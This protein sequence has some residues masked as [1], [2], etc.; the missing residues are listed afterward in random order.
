MRNLFIIMLSVLINSNLICQQ[1]PLSKEYIV[2]SYS[3][4]PAYAGINGG[5][6]LF[7]Q[8]RKN[9][10]GQVN[11]P[12]I[13]KLSINGSVFNHVG[14][15]LNFS[16]YRRGIFNTISFETSYS[17]QILIKEEHLISFGLSAILLKNNINLA[18]VD[19]LGY[20]PYFN[21]ESNFS[22]V[23]VNFGTGIV[24]NYNGIRLGIT[25]PLLLKNKIKN[26]GYVV[27][28]TDS[29]IGLH[30]GYVFR[31]NLLTFYPMILLHHFSGYN[32]W[33][34]SFLCQLRNTVWGGLSFGKNKSVGICLGGA[35]FENVI[36]NYSYEL[37]G[38]PAKA[39]Y[40]GSHELNV[41]VLINKKRRTNNNL[42]MF[43]AY[44][45]QPYHILLEK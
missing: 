41:G 34:G 9:L 40:S 42:S 17:Y 37:S 24:Y 13:N 22:T 6:E 14:L 15:G 3:I 19:E 33:E 26:N 20:D 7:F 29:N 2:N 38:N 31:H 45:K 25:A 18:S 30:A 36:I 11:S 8:A 28:N 23:S 21:F 5:F 39:A 43:R 16:E 1:I 12:E 32:Y 35:P 44:N 27:Y 10:L 4:S